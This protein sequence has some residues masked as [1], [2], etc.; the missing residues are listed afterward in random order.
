MSRCTC[1]ISSSDDGSPGP[2]RALS[3]CSIR[4]RRSVSTDSNISCPDCSVITW[5]RMAPRDRTSR[6]RGL[7]LVGSSEGAVSSVR[8][9]CWSS[10][11]HRGLALFGMQEG[12]RQNKRP[13]RVATKARLQRAL[14]AER[15]I[16]SLLTRNAMRE[17]TQRVYLGT[18]KRYP[19]PRSVFKN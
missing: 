13:S 6:R 3:R 4:S 9:V 14:T 19:M 18:S 1:R 11:F 10:T 8:R 15:R 5:P 16:H 2:R 17:S 12:I 7:S